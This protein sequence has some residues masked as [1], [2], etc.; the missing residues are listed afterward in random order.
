MCRGQDLDLLFA[1]AR[2][3]RFLVR[4]TRP[5]AFLATNCASDDSSPVFAPRLAFGL[6]PRR[7]GF[8]GAAAAAG[9]AGAA[10][11]GAF[12]DAFADFFRRGDAIVR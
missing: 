11:G 5:L 2:F 9:L 6:P 1:G 10:A 12:A 7:L 8:A 3:A 4:R